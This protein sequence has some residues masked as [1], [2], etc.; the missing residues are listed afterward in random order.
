MGSPSFSEEPLDQLRQAFAQ[1]RSDAGAPP[2]PKSEIPP[3]A[4]QSPHADR[5]E[6]ATDPFVDGTDSSSVSPARIIEAIL[7]VGHTENRPL[8]A[9]LIAATLRGMTPWEVDH[10]IAEL[11]QEY[12][13]EGRPYHI[14]ATGD[15]YELALH[16]TYD[17]LRQRFFGRLRRTRLSQA[18][19]DILA[20]V[21]YKQPIDRQ[22]ID[23]LRGRP[24]G[25][26]LTQLVRRQLLRVERNS[27]RNLVYQ[28]TERF[29]DLFQ[30]DSLDELPRDV[31]G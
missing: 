27:S 7:F 5:N 18:A 26:L 9:R 1:W 14:I 28:T 12:A 16:A 22:Q 8:S 24:S 13:S 21:A 30:L 25:P 2:S 19:I 31:I 4:G 6:P 17:G 11:N 15:G 29:L 20:I 10:C 3:S 23:S